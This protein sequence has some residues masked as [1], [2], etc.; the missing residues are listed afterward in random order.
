M[1][2]YSPTVRRKHGRSLKR[3]LD[4]WERN[5]STSGPT[6]WQIYDDDKNYLIVIFLYI[7]YI[8]YI[9]PVVLGP[10]S[11]SITGFALTLKRNNTLCMTPLYERSVRRRYI[12]LETHT[13]T[14]NHK[15]QTSVPPDR[16]QIQSCRNWAASM[17]GVIFLYEDI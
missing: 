9:F 16:I 12:Y 1:K 2:P 5:G 6:L 3:L 10:Y 11:L 14:H 7:M 15:R 8:I 4:T 17:F 13:Y